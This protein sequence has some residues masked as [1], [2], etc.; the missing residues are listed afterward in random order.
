MNF[1][2]PLGL[3]GLIGV[4]IVVLIYILKNKYNEQTVPSTYLWILSEKF[5]KRR[6]PFS[7]LTGIISLILQILTVIFVSLAIARPIFV[8][9]ESANEYCFILDCS[10]SMKMTDNGEKTRFEM[11]KEKIASVIDEAG[12]G[13]TYTLVSANAESG[14][15]FERLTDKKLAVELLESVECTDG[16]IEE[17]D[18]LAIAQKYYDENRSFVT[19][20]LTDKEYSECNGITLVNLA[21]ADAV[22]YSVSDVE[23]VLFGGVLSVTANVTSHTTDDEVTVELYVNGS[24]APADVIKVQ[25]TANEPAR[26]ELSATLASYDR[27]E[28]RVADDD[29]LDADNS[30]IIYNSKSESSY[31]I[32]VVSETPFF[33]E[34]ALDALTDS[35]VDVVEPDDYVGQEGYG[36][37]IFHSFTPDVLPD[38]AVW[39]VN[40]TSSVDDSGFGVRGVVELEEPSALVKSDSTSSIART[41]LTGIDGKNIFISEYVKYSG[42]YAKFTTLFSYNSNPVIFAGTNA[43]G[44][45]EVVIGFDLHK[46]DFSLSVDFVPL[47]GNLLAYSCPDVLDRTAYV[48]G[49]DVNVNITANVINVKALSPSGE[50]IYIDSS[51]DIGV[52]HLDKVGTYTVKVT[53]QNAVQ[54][55]KLYSATPEEE[56]E[57]VVAEE[58][59]SLVGDREFVKTDGEYDPLVI[60]FVCLALVFCADWM[61]YCYEKYQLR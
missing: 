44:N 12:G 61:V 36:L 60:L 41:M 27:F 14:A 25:L 33:L 6:N 35:V 40:A 10:G 55:Y 38:A 7:G 43:L 11:A 8:I 19:Y 52:L 5:F 45:R 13:S 32:L 16:L 3:L 17:G 2:Y 31:D 22:N 9:P 18:A 1:I 54:E 39:L 26:V 58:S 15:V 30:V 57:P 28:V 20:F 42:M 29:D 4:P 24:E 23:G 21:S 48:S 46:A 51:T 56:S 34:A 50:E 59:Y 49:E 47:L 53:T 37:Y